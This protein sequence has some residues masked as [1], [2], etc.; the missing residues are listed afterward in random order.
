M[1]NSELIEALLEYN[2][3][4]SV[5]VDNFE[6]DDSGTEVINVVNDK[7]NNTIIL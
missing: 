3:H 5:I 4:A 7:A 2:E 6:N 1:K